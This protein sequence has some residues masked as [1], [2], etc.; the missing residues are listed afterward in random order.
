MYSFKMIEVLLVEFL[1]RDHRM[2]VYEFGITFSETKYY[3]DHI[4]KSG[5]RVPQSKA[6]TDEM[7]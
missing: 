2:K 3:T 1:R 4:L 6:H 5:G 7:I